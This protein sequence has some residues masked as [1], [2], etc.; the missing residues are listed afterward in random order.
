MTISEEAEYLFVYGT[1]LN[2]LGHPGSKILTKHALLLG[3]AEFQGRMYEVKDYPGVVLSHTPADR[4]KGE[5]YLLHNPEKIFNKID[6]YEGYYPDNPGES[7][8][9]RKKKE[10]WFKKEEDFVIAWIYIFNRPTHSLKLIRS[11]DYQSFVRDK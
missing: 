10:V 9:I 11:G 2:S 8:Y 4:V 5:L 1:L 7:L 3:K 6:R